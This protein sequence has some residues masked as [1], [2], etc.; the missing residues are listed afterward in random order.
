MGSRKYPTHASGAAAKA[1]DR[2]G[3]L[4]VACSCQKTLMNLEEKGLIRREMIDHTDGSEAYGRYTMDID[5]TVTVT[6]HRFLEG[7]IE[8]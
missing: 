5:I 6:E 2:R 3:I 1:E 8:P 4:G 7:S